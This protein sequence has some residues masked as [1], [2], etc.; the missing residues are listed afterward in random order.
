[1][2]DFPRVAPI[3]DSGS[4]VDVRNLAR[5]ENQIP[6]N[7]P[8]RFGF[9]VTGRLRAIVARWRQKVGFFVQALQSGEISLKMPSPD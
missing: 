3:T 2:A 4:S 5:E 1:M 7:R 6:Y 9:A 8:E